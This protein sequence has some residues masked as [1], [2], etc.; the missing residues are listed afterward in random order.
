[1]PAAHLAMEAAEFYPTLPLQPLRSSVICARHE[2][3][4][5]GASLACQLYPACQHVTWLDLSSGPF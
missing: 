4:Q 5:F 2:P 3:F 1:M